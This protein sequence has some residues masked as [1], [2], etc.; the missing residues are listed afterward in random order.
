[1]AIAIK[2]VKWVGNVMTAVDS[3]CKKRLEQQ[4]QATEN[5]TRYSRKKI[6]MS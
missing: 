4:K 3:E 5:H 1:M 6:V 2:R